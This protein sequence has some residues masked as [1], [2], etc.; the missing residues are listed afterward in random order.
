[1]N[2]LGY[3]NRTSFSTGLAISQVS[4][5]SLIL[6]ALGLSFGQVNREVVSLI[7]LVGVLTISGSTYFILHTERIYEKTKHL[8]RLVEL[9]RQPAYEKDEKV[10]DPEM[11]IFGYDRVG[12]DFVNI[13]RKLGRKYF[14]V[15]FDPRSIHKLEKSRIP[16]YFG[17][18]E[19]VNFLS[20]IGVAKAKAII[21]T[22]PDFKT[23]LNL[24]SFYRNHNKTGIVI[25]ISHNIKDT[26]ELYRK[27]ASFVV[28]PHYLGAK[29][30]ARMI[31]N[32]GLRSEEFE[33][34]KRAHLEDL[35]RRLALTEEK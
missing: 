33:R 17:D 14:V 32:Y 16:F 1:M 13:A 12:Y 8:L 2:I 30:A 25:V 20:D 7:T 6:L 21:S 27:G 34:E 24:V 23:N 29:H 26:K 11:I 9:R 4:E 3:K 22:I 35:E 5:F 28:M 18:A 15:D 10:I 31:E 19:D